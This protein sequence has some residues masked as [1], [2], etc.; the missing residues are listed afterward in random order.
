MNCKP[1]D[2]AIV[3]HGS[4]SGMLVTCIRTVTGG[5]FK[6]SVGLEAANI[7]PIWRIDSLI[8]WGPLNEPPAIYVPYALD[9]YLRPIRGGL[10]KEQMDAELKELEGA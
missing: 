7:S 3:I 8:P 10:T 4:R 6:T 1:G 9:K 2:M 5:E